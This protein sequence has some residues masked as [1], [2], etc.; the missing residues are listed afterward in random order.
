[1][2]N[3]PRIKYEIEK[4]IGNRILIRLDVYEKPFKKEGDLYKTKGGIVLPEKN[5]IVNHENRRQEG[6]ETGTVIS[7]GHVAYKAIGDGNKWC[8]VGDRVGFKRY[9]GIDPYPEGS[10]DGFKYRCMDD[11]DVCFI[12]KKEE[13]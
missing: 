2:E 13:K 7:M 8:D 12:I 3:Q 11:E 6:A 5:E 4:A 10:P 9:A 1:M